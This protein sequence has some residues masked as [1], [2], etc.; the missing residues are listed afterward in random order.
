MAK[1]AVAFMS[2]VRS[3]DEHEN[4]RLTE[5][6]KRLSGEVRM[7]TG[8]EFHIFQDRSDIASGSVVAATTGICGHRRKSWKRCITS[9]PTR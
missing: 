3:D 9:M 7:Q 2:Y 6:C 8:E 1:S 4:G 5:F